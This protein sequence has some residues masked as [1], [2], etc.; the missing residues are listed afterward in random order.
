MPTTP[1]LQFAVHKAAR[2]SRSDARL[3]VAN[4]ET[5]AIKTECVATM[6]GGGF[7]NPT[8]ATNQ[9]SDGS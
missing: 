9:S 8:L 3:R 2:G 1:P 5:Y 4:E 7:Q 6:S